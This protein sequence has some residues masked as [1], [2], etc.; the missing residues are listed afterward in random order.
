MIDL[1][2]YKYFGSDIVKIICFILIIGVLCSWGIYLSRLNERFHFPFY[3]LCVV[4]VAAIILQAFYFYGGRYII[5]M[6]IK[7]EEA[8][9]LFSSG[10]YKV[11]SSW[12]D[13]S[14]IVLERY[15]NKFIAKNGG[16]FSQEEK[17][18]A[19]CVEVHTRNGNFTFVHDP[20][21]PT[22]GLGDII[23]QLKSRAIN[24]KITNIDNKKYRLPIE[25]LRR[26]RKY[27]IRKVNK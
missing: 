27:K 6:R 2:T 10:G 11:T 14:E 3:E 8:K 7:I 4:T 5:N 23:E 25:V 22:F 21:F 13:V 9:V 1:K 19:C 20:T 24:A 17:E 15:T 16:G 12:E 18:F 26:N